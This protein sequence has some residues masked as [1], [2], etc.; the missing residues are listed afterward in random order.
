MFTYAQ[1]SV[2]PSRDI[3]P[4]FEK[5]RQLR[6][7]NKIDLALEALDKAS[8]QAEKNEDINCLAFSK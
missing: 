8:E 5:A 7:E 2:P 3:T 1:D 6:N 4:Y